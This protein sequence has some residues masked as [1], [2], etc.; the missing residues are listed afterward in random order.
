MS[1]ANPARGEAELG[2]HKLI[3]DFNS[4]CS[5]EAAMGKKVPEI[6]SLMDSGMGFSD[7]RTCVRVFLDGDI[8]LEEAGLLIG[9]V[10]YA[11]ALTA[12]STAVGGFFAPQKKDKPNHPLKAA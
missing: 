5:L 7:L 3:V 8:S 10:G 11:D 12:I 2:E 1:A 9:E 4:L 6:L